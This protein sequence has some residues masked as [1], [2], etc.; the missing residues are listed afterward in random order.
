MKTKRNLLNLLLV[1]VLIVSPVV[2]WSQQPQE[3]ELSREEILFQRA[4]QSVERAQT[5]V[6]RAQA[7]IDEGDS[8]MRTGEQMMDSAKIKLKPANEEKSNMLK[9]YS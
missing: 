9:S 1:L 6:D 2:L 4:Q 8:L 7:Y 3:Q 5:S